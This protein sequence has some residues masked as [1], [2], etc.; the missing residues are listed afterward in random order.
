MVRGGTSK[1]ECVVVY[2]DNNKVVKKEK[3]QGDIITV[4][5]NYAKKLIDEWNAETSD[6]IVLRDNYTLTLKKPIKPEI[7][8]TIRKFGVRHMGDKVEVTIPVYEL[9]YS[10]RWVEESFQ[11]DSLILIL[12]YLGDE[13]TDQITETVLKTL[14]ARQ[15]EE[16]ELEEFP[17]E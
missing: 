14:T 16:E 12:P 5:K 7:V 10:N 13:V 11:A 1:E 8:D 3:V 9:L 2:I 6:F 15:E 17:E 4:V